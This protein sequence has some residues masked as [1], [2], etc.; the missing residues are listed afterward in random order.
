MLELAVGLGVCLI[1]DGH[2]VNVEHCCVEH[3]VT[4][5]PL[6]RIRRGGEKMRERAKRASAFWGLVCPSANFPLKNAL[7][8]NLVDFERFRSDRR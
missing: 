7:E 3:W 8:E 6:S 5:H 2:G 4:R 1:K